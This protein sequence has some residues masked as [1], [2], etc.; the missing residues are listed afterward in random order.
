[1]S[2][3]L[4]NPFK[5]RLR[6]LPNAHQPYQLGCSSSGLAS[7]AAA[8]MHS[9]GRSRSAPGNVDSTQS[10]IA[11]LM[12]YS[13]SNLADLF[14]QTPLIQA[15]VSTPWGLFMQDTTPASYAC[16]RSRV[17]RVLM[18]RKCTE[19]TRISFNISIHFHSRVLDLK[20]NTH[21]RGSR[22]R[23]AQIR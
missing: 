23:N 13:P 21:H 11:H 4:H 1:M 14:P 16:Q 22:S 17:V 20:E 15:N 8:L 10:L 9:T 5:S 12:M 18:I 19:K 2:I 3:H 6:R 7:P